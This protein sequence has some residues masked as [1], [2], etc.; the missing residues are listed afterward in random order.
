MLLLSNLE[1]FPLIPKLLAPG[2]QG[3]KNSF[4]KLAPLIKL[5]RTANLS[6]EDKHL[7]WDESESN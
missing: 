1:G 5:P 7:S 4:P 3:F 6:K 2:V